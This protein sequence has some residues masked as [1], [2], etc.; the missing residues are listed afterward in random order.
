M[1]EEKFKNLSDAES[2]G[3]VENLKKQNQKAL[4]NCRL[5][6]SNLDPSAAKGFFHSKC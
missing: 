3:T 4:P 5:P 6:H 2:L 1:V